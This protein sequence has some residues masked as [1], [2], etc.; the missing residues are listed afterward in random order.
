[1]PPAGPDDLPGQAG[2]A[3][4]E[5]GGPFREPGCR[6]L[7]SVGDGQ[8]R[9]LN[10]GFFTDGPDDLPPGVGPA[11]GYEIGL[12][13]APG[14]FGRQD[15]RPDEIRHVDEVRLGAPVADG[16]SYPPPHHFDGSLELG[17]AG[18][19]HVRGPEDGHRE[20]VP[21]GQDQ[22]FRFEL[23]ASVVGDGPGLAVL[24]GGLALRARPGGGDARHE[25]ETLEPGPG[26]KAGFD[27]I[28]GAL[29]VGRSV[30]LPVG[31]A[32]D[33]S[34]MKND[35][36]ILD[37]G[38]Q[39]RLVTK[40]PDGEGYRSALKEARPARRAHQAGHLG[41]PADQL[42][43]EMAPDEAAG[44]RDQRFHAALSVIRPPDH[45]EWA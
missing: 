34:Q 27:E 26:R 13:D 40:I 9:P 10:A 31:G 22:L 4:A 12:S 20:A 24:V 6:E 43:D 19:E 39:G 3:A 23:A 21:G 1:M 29:D 14:V 37:G 35:V 17:L 30:G 16:R 45:S 8:N 2:C 11:V 25:E 36:L 33:R 18:A 15:Q 7:N 41:A 28:P 42:L 44:A 5:A 38:R 32:D